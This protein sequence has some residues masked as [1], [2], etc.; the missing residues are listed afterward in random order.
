MCVIERRF[1]PLRLSKSS[2]DLVYDDEA[3]ADACGDIHDG[4]HSIYDVVGVAKDR[5]NTDVKRHVYLLELVLFGLI[6][7][8][9]VGLSERADDL[10]YDDE[11]KADT[12]GHIDHRHQSIYDVLGVTK[13]RSNVDGETHFIPP[14]SLVFVTISYAGKAM[15]GLCWCAETGSPRQGPADTHPNRSRN[16]RAQHPGPNR[17]KEGQERFLKIH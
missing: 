7:T 17:P 16:D 6:E 8:G 11:A 5:S 15:T 2:D 14:C 1:T 12:C 4:Q 10:V 3:E 9:T 13:D